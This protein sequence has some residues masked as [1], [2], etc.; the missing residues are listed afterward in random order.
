MGSREATL[1]VTFGVLIV[2]SAFNQN[3]VQAQPS[4]KDLVPTCMSRQIDD[5]SRF[6][7]V[8]PASNAKAM[9]AKGF[10]IMRCK[11]RSE[12]RRK[13]VAG[14]NSVCS[15]AAIP[16]EEV[17]KRFEEKYGERPAVLCGMAELVTG[18]WER[19]ANR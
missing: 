7:I 18:R 4:D 6:S 11:G 14:R 15:I 5:G 16:D 12:F 10:Q 1:P 19:K 17:Q 3:P 13:R 8:V 9:E 2:A